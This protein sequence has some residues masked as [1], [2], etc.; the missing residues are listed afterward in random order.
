M[1]ERV[2]AE[3]VGLC[4][5]RLARIAPWMEG[6]VQAGKLPGCLTA[7]LRKGGLAYL[8]CSGMAD[9]ETQRK[10][11]A[12][13]VFRIHSMTKPI[14]TAAAM[15][16]FEE[17]RFQLDD[18]LSRFLPEF[19]NTPVWVE[20]EGVTM[21]TEP[22]ADSLK[23]WHLMTHTAGLVYGARNSSPVGALCRERGIDFSRRN[24]GSLAD[25]VRALAE[26]PLRWQ[27][28]T[29]WEYSVA[30]DVL[31]R[32]VEVLAGQSLDRVLQQRIF[33][34]LAMR[35]S[36]FALQDGQLA[37]FA[38]T[39]NAKDGGLVLAERPDQ[40]A[41]HAREVTMF[42]GGGGLIS[43]ADDYL[44]FAEAMR[45]KGA[46]AGA[47][48][49]GRRTVELMSMNH[50]P[51]NTDLA[52]MGTPVH[53]ET[54]YEGIG[55]G[56]GFSVVLDPARAKAACSVGECAWGGAASTAFWIDPVEDLVVVFLT[57]LMPS[58]TYPIRRELRALVYQALTD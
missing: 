6:Y 42:S 25:T 19:T 49:L 34:P 40:H 17:G 2:E 52:G 8:N 16:F 39:Y 58:S 43:S 44:R 9:I 57:Q 18:P 48:I 36:G 24:G 35:D 45:C 54:S 22:V 26:I 51:D 7:V 15:T 13:T 23:I 5:Q 30:T 29:R 12:D 28:G 21:R 31:G 32:L 33:D 53:S 55:F 4:S 50:L 46:L 14:V 10:V 11:T 3:A 1:F 27:P 56:L 38:A 37:R 20:G 41:S 47:R